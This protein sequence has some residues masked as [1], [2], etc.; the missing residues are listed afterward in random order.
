MSPTPAARRRP[1]RKPAGPAAT[2]K[3][4]VLDIARV[5]EVGRLIERLVD[6]ETDAFLA[7]GQAYRA[8]HRQASRREL[9]PTE[10]AQIAVALADDP[11]PVEQRIAAVQNA[12]GLHACDEPT[13]REVLFAAGARTAPAFI[14]TM[15]RVVA[16]IEMPTSTFWQ[17]LD[18]EALDEVLDQHADRLRRIPAHEGRE[19]TTRALEHFAAA[20]GVEGPKALGLAGQIIRQALTQAM[21]Q[22]LS[23]ASPSASLTHSS[24][25]ATAGADASS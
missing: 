4:P 7:A 19:R 20:A 5:E 16:L 1:A 15:R 6:E 21:S 25:P 8:R 18:D 14:A 2:P 12:E 10:A 22:I 23:D 13:P 17:A 9:T 11:R 3:L 24:P